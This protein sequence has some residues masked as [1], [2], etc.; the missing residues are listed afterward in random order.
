MLQA[1][2]WT[3]RLLMT[4]TRILLTRFRFLLQVKQRLFISNC[5]A[6][7]LYIIPLDLGH[8]RASCR[9]GVLVASAFPVDNWL[10][11]VER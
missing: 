6:S 3:W 7:V 11:K 1:M 10:S 4:S 5:I 9:P 2:T 8:L